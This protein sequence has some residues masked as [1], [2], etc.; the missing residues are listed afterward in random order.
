MS[1]EDDPRWIW[2]REAVKIVPV[3]TLIAWLRLGLVRSQAAARLLQPLPRGKEKVKTATA[4]PAGTWDLFARGRL[5]SADLTT[6]VFEAITWIE[7]D[8]SGWLPANGFYGRIRIHAV[9]V[10]EGDI[11]LWLG[12]PSPDYPLPQSKTTEPRKRPAHRPSLEPVGLSIF[13]GRIQN[14]LVRQSRAEEARAIIKAWSA[15]NPPKQDTVSGWL[16]I[17]LGSAVWA[18]GRLLNHDVIASIVEQRMIRIKSA[19]EPD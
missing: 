19:F 3:S 15:E 2:F 10:S 13:R 1:D 11:R 5:R 8:E 6:G 7:D 4:V 18:E 9:Q 17:W 14:G 16:K 12:S